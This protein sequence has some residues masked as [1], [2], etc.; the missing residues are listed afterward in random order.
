LATTLLANLATPVFNGGA[1]KADVVVAQSSIDEALSD[2][3]HIALSAFRDVERQIDQG[4]ILEQQEEELSQALSDA[5]DALR[6][7]NF[8]YESGESDL[9]NV[10]SAQQRV[11]FIEAQLVSTQRARLVQYINLSLALGIEPIEI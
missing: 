11:S 10:L 3:Q 8:R 5:Q 2:Y 6:F 7:T 9:F 4:Q 1:L